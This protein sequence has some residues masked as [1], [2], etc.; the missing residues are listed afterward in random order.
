[1][2]AN[3]IWFG[4]SGPR[5]AEIVL[6]G[7]SWGAAEEAAKAPFCGGSGQELNR[8]LQ[9]SGFPRDSIFCTNVVPARP[10]ANDMWRFFEPAKGNPNPPIRGLHPT[11]IVHAGLHALKAQIAEIKPKLVIAAGNYA[12]WALTNCTGYSIPADAEGRRC[13]SGIESWRGSMWYADAS[14]FPNTKLLPI[15]HPAAIMREWYKRP[16][17]KHDLSTRIRQGLAGDWR[18]EPPVVYAPPTFEVCVNL[19]RAWLHYADDFEMR[20][21]CDIE[22]ARGLMTCIGFASSERCAMTVPF[23]KLSPPGFDSYWSEDEENEIVPLIRKLL[24]HPN[25]HIEG[26]NFLYDTQYI[27][28]F[29][30]TIPRL[31]FDTMLAHHLLFPGTPKGLDYLSSLY[32]TYH[33]Y[34]K[35]DGKE[36]DTRGDL[37]SHLR[38]NALDCLRTFEVATVLRKLIVTMEQEPQWK[39]EK[40]KNSLALRMMLR[41]IRV[42]QQ[43]RSALALQLA[44]AREQY[45]SWFERMFPQSLSETSSETKWYDSVYQQRDIFSE[46]FGLRLP[47]H[48][49]TGQ[50]TFGK[51]ALG[52]L[53]TRHPEFTRLFTALRDYRSLGVFFNTFV[54]APL[55]PDG[56]MRCMFN[57]AGTETFRWSSSSNAFGRGTNLQNIPAGTEE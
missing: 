42:D 8:L 51:E 52:T 22:T 20:L 25:I 56:R 21:V 34:W 40:A 32:C 44:T 13:P 46:Q 35:D 33:W 29:L 43:R 27:Y 39:E 36:W 41:G 48:R 37:E 54:K 16:V 9:E 47:L 10:L 50:P 23:V 55:D 5:N 49:K 15:I 1:M 11:A 17:T 31:D 18:P 19:L 4:T 26:Q 28:A 3:D 30:A 38:Y 45:A 2:T 7:E 24:S 57:T 12:L 14:P 6:V 53:T